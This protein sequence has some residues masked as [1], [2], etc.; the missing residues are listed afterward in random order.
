[1][2]G[3]LSMFFLK[4]TTT[5]LLYRHP[6]LINGSLSEGEV[7]L[8]PG[9]ARW[10]TLHAAKMKGDLG[11]NST[12]E[13]FLDLKNSPDMSSISDL[14]ELSDSLQAGHTV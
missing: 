2:A 14:S 8:S 13:A 10:S 9:D 7:P 3:F 4:V 6:V 5:Y 1:M 11:F 12:L